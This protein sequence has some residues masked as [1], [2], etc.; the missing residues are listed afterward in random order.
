MGH[1]AWVVG[2]MLAGLVLACGDGT[3]VTD[4]DL[5]G[6]WN[7]TEF[8]FSDFGDP[9]MDFHVIEANGTASVVMRADGTYTFTLTMPFSLPDVTSG[10][11]ELTS[12]TQ[13]VLTEQ[14]AADGWGMRVS[15][16]GSALTIHSED[17]TFDFGSGEIP[18]QL[19]A[20]FVRQ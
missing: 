7:A 1:R 19:D 5:V 6:T 4:A 15:L 9:V 12:G 14:G 20:T 3:G 16:A 13:L 8:T 2:P 11:W 18:A 10:A 17:V